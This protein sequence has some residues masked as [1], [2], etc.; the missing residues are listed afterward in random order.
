MEIQ[1]NITNSTPA[2][3]AAMFRRLRNLLSEIA[4]FPNR[5]EQATVMIG[6][7]IEEG[8]DETRR[9]LP[10]MAKLGFN[11]QHAAIILKRY[12]GTD[13]HT[14]LWTR[15]A[16]GHYSLHASPSATTVAISIH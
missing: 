5:N 16:S 3:D 7:C 11:R 2:A 13:P 12:E 10:A 14:H 9:L 1:I 4:C 6:A 15:D 8:M